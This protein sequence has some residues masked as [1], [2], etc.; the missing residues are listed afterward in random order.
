MIIGLTGPIAA[1]KDEVAKVLR[2]CG[3][4]IIEVDRLAHTLYRNQSPVWHELV[5]AFGSKIL[6]RGGE[7]NR[8]KLGELVFADQQKLRLLNKIVHPDLKQAVVEKLATDN[9]QP[10]TSIV[11][12]AALLKEIGLV[13]VVDQVWVV[14]A[15]K[16]ARLRRLI[17][18]G[19][20]KAAAIKRV[21]SQLGQKEYLKLA[22]VILNNNSTINALRAAAKKSWSARLTPAP[23]TP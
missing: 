3:A 12:N 7:I 1:G 20:P 16:T 13:D 23:G 17:K 8:K 11:I 4:E 9:L 14:M 10:A 18:S 22:D 15:P 2:R 6:N 21:N 19:L 5:R